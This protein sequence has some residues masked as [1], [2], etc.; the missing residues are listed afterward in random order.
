MDN[1]N[2]T[3]IRKAA[4]ITYAAFREIKQYV[5]VGMRERQLAW[6]MGRLLVSHGSRK[7]AFPVIVA[8]GEQAAEPHHVPGARSLRVGD[9]IKIDAGAVW[10]DMRGDVT[11]TYFFG[12][13]P[14]RKF[15]QRYEAVYEA[16]RIAFAHYRAGRT[17]Q[18]ID[19]V[20]RNYLRTRRLD[21]LFIHSLGHGVGRAIH[22]P[23]W[24]TP[25]VQRGSRPLRVGE[26]ITN[27]P[28]VYESGWGGIRIEDM[29]EVTARGP[30]WLGYAP[31]QLRQIII[32]PL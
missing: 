20:A 23:P 18:Q 4:D 1:S 8:F 6:R 9:M 13:A 32:R 12:K 15:I 16:Q 17:G 29:L 19:A 26:V 5:R 3:H 30:K 2:S 25:S 22:Q 7:H 31:K 28:G 11:R 24:I 14:S 27:E 10:H 21:K